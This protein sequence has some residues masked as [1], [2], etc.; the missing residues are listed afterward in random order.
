MRHFTENTGGGCIVDFIFTRDWIATI[1]EE[2]AIFHKPIETISD[3]S[4]EDW[5]ANVFYDGDAALEKEQIGVIETDIRDEK[6]FAP[7]EGLTFVAEIAGAHIKMTNGK[8]ITFEDIKKLAIP[9][10][11]VA[12]M[13]TQKFS[14]VAL[15]QTE[16]QAREAMNKEWRSDSNRDG[17]LD[18]DEEFG[19]KIHELPLGG[20]HS[21]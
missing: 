11:F 1:N 21:E 10:Y 5:V 19:I 16:Q 12:T 13:E 15:G 8:T 4:V 9:T 7:L 20:A 3:K 14:F 2:I 18:L 17:H 6:E